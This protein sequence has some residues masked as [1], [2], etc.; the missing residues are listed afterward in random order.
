MR[1]NSMSSMRNALPLS[2]LFTFWAEHTDIYWV[3]FYMSLIIIVK[4]DL[5]GFCCHNTLWHVQTAHPQHSRAGASTIWVLVL[6]KMINMNI[7]KTLYSST[8][9]VLIFQYSYSYVQYLPLPCN[10][11]TSCLHV[12]SCLVTTKPYRTSLNPLNTVGWAIGVESI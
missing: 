10:I 1:C 3:K 2:T 4:A 5:F 9:R 12:P 6:P 11:E 7:L 8:T